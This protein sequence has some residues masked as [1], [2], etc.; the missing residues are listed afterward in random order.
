[1]GRTGVDLVSA[2]EGRSV[3]TIENEKRVDLKEAVEQ[4][5]HSFFLSSLSGLGLELPYGCIDSDADRATGLFK[6]LGGELM[7]RGL[8]TST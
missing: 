1:M 7:E 6:L 2:L 3:R 4:D 5:L 8:S